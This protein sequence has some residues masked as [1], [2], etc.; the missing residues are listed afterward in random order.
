[1]VANLFAVRATHPA[2]MRKAIDPVGP[3][4][5]DWVMEAVARA[6]ARRDAADRGPVIC[7]WGTHGSYMDQDQAVLGW[8]RGLCTPMALG[9]TRN[10]LPW[11]PLYV[12]Y[13]AE[14]MPLLE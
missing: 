9:F 5:H 2:D 11:H 3:E 10:G 6:G 8:V 4:N 12:P 1:V 14:L 7:A 13:T